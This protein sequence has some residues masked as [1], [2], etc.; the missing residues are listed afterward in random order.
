MRLG[1]LIFQHKDEIKEN[2]NLA[3]HKTIVTTKKANIKAKG[4]YFKTNIILFKVL[5]SFT[6]GMSTKC[7][8]TNVHIH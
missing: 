5:Y 3:K 4:N 2:K 6:H 8:Q 7:T 1:Y